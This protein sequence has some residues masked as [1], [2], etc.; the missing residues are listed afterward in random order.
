MNDIQINTENLKPIRI[1]DP[2]GV[3][4]DGYLLIDPKPDKSGLVSILDPVQNSIF[5]INPNRVEEASTNGSLAAISNGAAIAACPICGGVRKITGDD[6]ECA[7][8]SFR[9]RISGK[10]KRAN[11]ES[12]KV[13]EKAKASVVDLSVLATKGELWMKSGINFDHDMQVAA[14]SYRIG[15]NYISFNLYN[16]SFGAKVDP[17]KKLVDNPNACY[18]IKSIKKWREKLQNKGYERFHN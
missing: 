7:C 6:G 17:V 3:L 12:H 9:V 4:R 10:N 11:S 16:Q 13:V 2:I 18:K 14:F 5:K 8:G 1:L 15:D